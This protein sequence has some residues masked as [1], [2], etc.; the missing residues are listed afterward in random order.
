L[1]KANPS[2]PILFVETIIFPHSYYD[3]N[4]FEII[5]EKNKLLKAEYEKI[6]QLSDKLYLNAGV[7][8]FVNFPDSVIYTRKIFIGGMSDN[9]LINNIK[10]AGYGMGEKIVE[11]ALVIKTDFRYNFWQYHNLLLKA[12]F[13]IITDKL[14]KPKQYDYIA[15][16]GLGYR[17]NSVVGPLELLVSNSILEK[18]YPKI[19]ISLG[20][21]L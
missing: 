3:Q 20:F 16:I 21:K 19:W 1:R 17:F 15:G 18:G 11:N 13:G 5:T 10:F 2:T 14:L 4:T 9:K 6:T 12:N 7:T 8:G